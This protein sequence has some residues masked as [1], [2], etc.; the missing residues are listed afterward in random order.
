[1]AKGEADFGG[2]TDFC[3]LLRSHMD[4]EDVALFPSAR[5]LLAD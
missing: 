2:C 3:E 1:M 4:R 5:G